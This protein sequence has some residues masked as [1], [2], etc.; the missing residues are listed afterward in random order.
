VVDLLQEICIGALPEQGVA[1]DD[2][3]RET[4]RP[5]VRGEVDHRRRKVIREEH[6]AGE[7]AVH[8]LARSLVDRPE[9]RRESRQVLDASEL[10]GRKLT[11]GDALADRPVVR[12]AIEKRRPRDCGDRGV[13]ALPDSDDLRPGAFSVL[14]GQVLPGTPAVA[15]AAQ[16]R[17]AKAVALELL[18]QGSPPPDLL[19]G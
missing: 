13:E 2:G 16:P 8:E 7:V 1:D 12:A 10:P 19:D 3:R 9:R 4:R 17:D 18:E 15:D 14:A 6:V 5:P 11:P